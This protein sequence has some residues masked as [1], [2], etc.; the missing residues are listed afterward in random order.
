[1]TVAEATERGRAMI[2]LKLKKVR[3]YYGTVKA[4]HDHPYVEVETEEEAQALVA[5]GYFDV[6]ASPTVPDGDGEG[7]DGEGDT[8]PD[9]EALS[10]MTK[11]ELTAYAEENGI[12]IS[13]CKTKADI[14]KAISVANGGSSTM[15]DL[16]Q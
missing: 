3:S 9:Y 10:E 4:T 7:K 12:D 1:M 11:A 13:E 2:K 14:L 6:C 8:A 15:I 16:Q 5:K